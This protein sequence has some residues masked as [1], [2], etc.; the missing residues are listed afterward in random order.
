[1]EQPMEQAMATP[2]VPMK[3][4]CM[5]SLMFPVENDNMAL[6]VKRKIDEALPIVDNKRYTF[7]ILET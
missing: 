2:K 3:K 4:A 7:Q 1:M 6:E 5:I